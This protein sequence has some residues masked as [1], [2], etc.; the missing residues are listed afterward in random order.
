MQ[1]K[2]L[3]AKKSQKWPRKMLIN[4]GHRGNSTQTLYEVFIHTHLELHSEEL[5]KQ[6]PIK[7]WRKGTTILRTDTHQRVG[8]VSVLQPLL[9]MIW[10]SLQQLHKQCMLC[11]GYGFSSSQ[12]I[13]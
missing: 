11:F 8:M 9:E 2:G 13:Q 6:V 5:K 3:N 4:I 7:L 1:T 12:S 10:P